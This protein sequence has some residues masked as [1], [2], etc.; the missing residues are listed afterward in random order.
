MTQSNAYPGAS[1]GSVE[2]EVLESTVIDEGV[3]QRLLRRAGRTIAR[4]ALECLELLLDNATPAQVRMTVLAALTYLVVPVD[5]IPDFIPAAGFSDDLVAITAL[6]GL[7]TRHRTDAIRQ[8]A[9]RK[10]DRWFPLGR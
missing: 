7:C 10:L 3:L 5:L 4:P 9:Q 8:R 2:A 1:S 6:L